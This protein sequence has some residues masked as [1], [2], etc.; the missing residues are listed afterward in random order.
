MEAW[1]IKFEYGDL[2]QKAEE[3]QFD[4]IIHG[5]NCFCAMGKGIALPIKKSWPEAYEADKKTKKGD[6]EKLGSYSLAEVDGLTIINL[7]TQYNYGSKDKADFDPYALEK[8]LEK[9]KE[10]FSGKRI[11]LPAIGSGLGKGNWIVIKDIIGKKLR[12]EDVTVVLLG[13]PPT[14]RK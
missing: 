4:V 7:Y 12:D 13:K 9:V 1:D 6:R 11:G 10:N 2:I 5:C 14:K 3:G 8:G